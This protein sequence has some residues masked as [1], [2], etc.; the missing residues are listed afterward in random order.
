MR[1]GVVG[2]G[3]EAILDQDIGVL[4]VA[5]AEVLEACDGLIGV[6]GVEVAE[7]AGAGEAGEVANVAAVGG[8]GFLSLAG[9]I[10]EFSLPKTS[11]GFFACL[12]RMCS[13]S[14]V[15]LGNLAGQRLQAN[16]L[17]TINAS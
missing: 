2:F 7:A 4:G 3:C 10:V 8:E 5:G 11:L 14:L 13:C 9:A 12:V 17:N 16:F 1:E 6:R 15:L